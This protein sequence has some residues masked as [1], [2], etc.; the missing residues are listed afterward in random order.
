VLVVLYL[1]I[2]IIVNNDTSPGILVIVNNDTSPGILV[3]VNNDTSPGILV[4]ISFDRV[5]KTFLKILASSTIVR[6]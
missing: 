1:T 3:I 4:A 5:Q 6:I 2:T